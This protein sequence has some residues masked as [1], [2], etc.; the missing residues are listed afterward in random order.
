MRC[1]VLC[2]LGDK[3]YN[4]ETELKGLRDPHI[5][6]HGSFSLMVNFDA[7]RHY[8]ESKG[9][10]LLL[11]LLFLLLL[12]EKWNQLNL[13]LNLNLNG[14]VLGFSMHT[15]YMDGFKV[16][17]F[18]AGAEKVCCVRSLCVCSVLICIQHYAL[19]FSFCCLNRVH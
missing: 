6:V 2:C 19:C 4:H 1:V 3:A 12:I 8:F 9:G 17:L 10:T 15:P 14:M 5:A 13:T 18:A 16:A 11:L 7:V